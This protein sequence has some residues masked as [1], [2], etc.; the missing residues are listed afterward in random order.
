MA[1]LEICGCSFGLIPQRH[2]LFSRDDNDIRAVTV[3]KHAE[4]RDVQE[5]IERA[6]E[7]IVADLLAD[8]AARYAQV[9][10]AHQ[11]CEHV[12]I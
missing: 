8:E 1:L 11:E 5:S 4:Q 7:A 10:W 12:S 3:N 9:D 2:T 6:F